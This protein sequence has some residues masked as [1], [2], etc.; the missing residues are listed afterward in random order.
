MESNS[1]KYGVV[2]V[3]AVSLEEARA[4]ARSLLEQKLAACINL[5]PV[6]SMYLWEGKLEQEDEYQLLIK[7]DLAKFAELAKHITTLHSYEVPEIIALPIVAGSQP[8]LDWL[9]ENINSN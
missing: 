6:N 4:I 2:M 5:F 3:T 1:A 7:T 9:G 8:Y